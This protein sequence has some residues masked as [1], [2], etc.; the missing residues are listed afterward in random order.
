[1]EGQYKGI[2]IVLIQLSKDNFSFIVLPPF[3]DL[4]FFVPILDACFYIFI[5]Q[6]VEAQNTQ[7]IARGR[8]ALVLGSWDF[9]RSFLLLGLILLQ[10][11]IDI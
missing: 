9:R 5:K 6:E 7:H 4:L 8:G 1:M 11:C 2:P 10:S 3:H